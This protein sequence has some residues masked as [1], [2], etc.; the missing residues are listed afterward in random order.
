M[1]VSRV[2]MFAGPNGSG[3]SDLI[4][5][6]QQSDLPLGPII[7]ADDFQVSLQNS[8][9]IDLQEYGLSDITHQE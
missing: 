6:L 4:R 7:N 9:F 8:G 1:A 2:R 3:K 5:R